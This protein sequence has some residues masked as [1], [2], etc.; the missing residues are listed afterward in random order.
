MT[1]TNDI[2]RKFWHAIR[3]DRTAMFWLEGTPG[4]K[5]MT[6][7]ID[8][9]SD[10]GPFWLFTSKQTLAVSTLQPGDKASLAFSAKGHDL[11]AS[12]DGTVSIDNDRGVIDRLW[13]P[14]IAAWYEGGKDDPNLV[15]LRFD[16]TEAKVWVD[17]SSLLAG[18]KLL[19]GSDPKKD[20][21][22]KVAQIPV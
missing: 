20:F 10:E 21:K 1:D 5:P 3:S 15:L 9:D 2:E 4:S 14:F 12:I 11:F 6:V 17:A 22:D 13:N 7:L 19:F 8:G 16:A 18:V